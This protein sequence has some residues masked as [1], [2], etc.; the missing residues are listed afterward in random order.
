MDKK[1]KILA[2]L[3]VETLETY[4][5][6]DAIQD[7]VYLMSDGAEDGQEDFRGPSWKYLEFLSKKPRNYVSFEK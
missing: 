4:R 7:A 5:H 6:Y 1:K 2:Q 3:F